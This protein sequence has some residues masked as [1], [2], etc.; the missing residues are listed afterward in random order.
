MGRTIRSPLSVH[1]T[2][3]THIPWHVCVYRVEY[4]TITKPKTHARNVQGNPGS[5][6]CMVLPHVIIMRDWCHGS[7][8]HW[9]HMT[10]DSPRTTWDSP[11]T[12]DTACVVPRCRLPREGSSTVSPARRPASHGGGVDSP[13][14]FVYRCARPEGQTPTVGELDSPVRVRLP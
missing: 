4:T 5:G 6:W 9:T 12:T 10:W 7:P 2:V 14:G 13:R 1:A 8:R 11:R 3:I